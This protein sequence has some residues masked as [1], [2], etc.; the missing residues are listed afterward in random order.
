MFVDRSFSLLWG[1]I[2]SA[3]DSADA[4]RSH[5]ENW[6]MLTYFYNPSCQ[7]IEQLLSDDSTKAEH[8]RMRMLVNPV[9]LLLALRHL[10]DLRQQKL[11]L[12]AQQVNS[13]LADHPV[14][15]GK[16]IASRL[17][18]VLALQGKN[19]HTNACQVVRDVLNFRFVCVC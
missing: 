19:K 10:M 13:Y 9:G 5:L 16:K 2:L 18:A 12:V 15:P 4:N 11:N 6:P 14:H 1:E 3:F 7:Q 17:Q 8:D